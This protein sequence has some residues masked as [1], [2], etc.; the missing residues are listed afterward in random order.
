MLERLHEAGGEREQRL[1]GAGLAE[2]RDEVDVRVHQGV[3]REILLAVARRD[4]PDVVPLVRVVLDRLQDR[5]LAG[6]FLDLRIERALG[7]LE[8]ELVDH[9]ARAQRAVQPVV[10]V[11]GLLPR[12]HAFAV[13]VPEIRRQFARAGVQKIGVFEHLVVEIVLGREPQR[14]RLDAHVDVFA[15]EDDLALG[16]R[17]LQVFHHADDLVVGLAAREPRRQLAADRLGLQEQPSRCV[18]AV[19]RAQLDAAFD[20]VLAAAHDFVEKAARLARVAR[21]FRHAFL[22]A[23][24][25]LERGHRNVDIVFLEA[26]QAG[27]IVHQH[28]GVEHEELDAGG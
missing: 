1:A 20:V 24:E 2:Q 12:L 17:L 26:E 21:D 4:A 22:V 23:V 3:E 14:T 5:G 19:V 6:D 11:P 9:H 8:N 16:M 28:V 15:D 13:L 25:F 27:R 18:A 10:G 7:L